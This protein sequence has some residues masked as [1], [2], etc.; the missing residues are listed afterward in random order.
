MSEDG[1]LALASEV[2]LVE[3]LARRN[4]AV[5]VL[6]ADLVTDTSEA[7][8]MWFRGGRIM[9]LGLMERGRLGILDGLDYDND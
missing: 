4:L 3:E 1:P 2:E 6:C 9:S 8:K 5:V 7:F